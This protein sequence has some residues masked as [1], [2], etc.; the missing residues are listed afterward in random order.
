MYYQLNIPSKLFC[1][2]P[3]LHNKEALICHLVLGARL[4][5]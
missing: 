3:K 2:L 4:G 5:S 1:S